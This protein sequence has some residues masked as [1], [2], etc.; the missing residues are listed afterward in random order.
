WN[1]V[2][3]STTL[4]WGR[5]PETLDPVRG[6]KIYDASAE[7]NVTT[8]F[9]FIDAWLLRD[10]ILRAYGKVD[11]L[12]D[13]G[14]ALR[15]F[16]STA[17]GELTV[18]LLKGGTPY[19]L[20]TLIGNVTWQHSSDPESYEYYAPSEVFMAGGN[21]VG[22]TWIGVG[23]GRVLGL[24][25]RAYGGTFQERTLAS[26]AFVPRIKGEAEA[27]VSLARGNSTW[28]LTAL[29]N[30]TYNAAAAPAWDYW[31]AFVRLGYSLKMPELLAP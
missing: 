24:S 27:N 13:Q 29:A 16:L 4:R 25:L 9:S 15:N 7:A 20:L 18:H 6:V 14:I 1:A 11:L 3:L 12:H 17:V 8:Q 21:L 5:Q 19:S 22:S 10:T 31:S 23:G 26:G 28:T 30:T 2:F